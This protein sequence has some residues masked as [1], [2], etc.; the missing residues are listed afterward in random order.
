MDGFQ[1]CFGFDHLSF[2]LW[3][4]YFQLKMFGFFGLGYCL[5]A[6]KNQKVLNASR[7]FKLK[8]GTFHSASLSH[9]QRTSPGAAEPPWLM[10]IPPGSVAHRQ[11][12]N[13]QRGRSSQPAK[14]GTFPPSPSRIVTGEIRSGWGLLINL[15]GPGPPPAPLFPCPTTAIRQPRSP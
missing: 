8:V 15:Y 11:T 4:N 6:V 9:E 13:L 3:F 7:C 5:S 1:S 10:A 12:Q 14:R 2:L